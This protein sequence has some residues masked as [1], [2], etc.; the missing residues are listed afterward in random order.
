MIEITQEI[1]IKDTDICENFVRSPGS[2]GQKV[3]KTATAVQLRFDA[4][5]SIALSNTVYLRLK[6]VAGKRMTKNGVIIIAAHQHAT[7][8]R[9]REDALDRLKNLIR[10]A[11]ML[12]KYRKKTNPTHGSKERR[13]NKKRLKS[14]VKRG[15][16]RL[17]T[18]DL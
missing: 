9:N 7:Q 18:F 13:L 17:R 10:K 12:P 16:G 6:L 4:R 11:V 5:N 2:G 3:N 15:R 8:E 1:F 14:N